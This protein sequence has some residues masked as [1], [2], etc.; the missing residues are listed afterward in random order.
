MQSIAILSALL[1]AH[2]PLTALVGSGAAARIYPLELPQGCLMPAIVIEAGV[3][4]P[5]TTD[6]M[7]SLG[8]VLR[9]AELTL[10]VLAKTPTDLV[11]VQLA[12]EAACQFQRGTIA[13]YN[14]ALVSAAT[15]GS[16]ETDSGKMLWYL[17]L[18]FS[19]T[20]RR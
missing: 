2:A 6:G 16:P 3:D 19:V 5:Q 7:A 1:N 4:A 12:A 10:H 13:G 17:P 8:Y 20:Y 18:E 11:A 15:V 14:V 9:I